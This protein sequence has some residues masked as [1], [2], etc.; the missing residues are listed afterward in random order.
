MSFP[1]L[2]LTFMDSRNL[3]PA[4]LASNN[5]GKLKEFRE[6]LADTHLSIIPQS[7]LGVPEIEETGLSFVENAI[8]KARNASLHSGLPA[9]A[10][11]S[12]LEVAILNGAP[13]IHSA[14]YAGNGI[15]KTSD[16]ENCK[17]LLSD[18]IATSEEERAAR[19]QCVLVL[20]RHAHDP[21]PLICQ[22]TWNGHI[23][24]TEQGEN[25]FGYDPL[26][27]V[28]THQCSA[29]ELSSVVKNQISHRAQAVS[30]LVQRLSI[31]L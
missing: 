15:G 25:G 9:L 19:F 29:A 4:V 20:I 27:Y 7:D 31:K 23:L 24:S 30:K 28:P 8:L 2:D 5:P 10:D 18:L 16:A 14:R 1:I 21:S 26:F 11:D 3:P 13:G 22:G 12:G 6:I 17:K